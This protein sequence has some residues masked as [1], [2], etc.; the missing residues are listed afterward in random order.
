MLQDLNQ[1]HVQEYKK[2]VEFLKYALGNRAAKP[3]NGKLSSVTASHH[4]SVISASMMTANALHNQSRMS[5]GPSAI[6]A[7]QRSLMQTRPGV[8]N[9]AGRTTVLPPIQKAAKAVNG[10]AL[11]GGTL[12]GRTKSLAGNSSRKPSN[13]QMMQGRG[14]DIDKTALDVNI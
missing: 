3:G 8:S 2:T 12:K 5:Q 11:E 6:K 7:R 9:P 10:G 13:G 1:R 14:L 4:K